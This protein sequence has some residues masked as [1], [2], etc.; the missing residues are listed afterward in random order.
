MAIVTNILWTSKD[1]AQA[2]HGELSGN[3]SATNLS[4]D[5]RTIEGGELFIAVRSENTDGHNYVADA[6]AKG[7]AAAVV[8]HRPDNVDANAP[9]IIV[10]DTQAA[11]EALGQTV[12]H[13][14]AARII[15]VTGSVGKTGTKNMLAKAFGA[16]GQVHASKAS[17]NNHLGVP[18]SL[19][20]MHE[21]TDFGI[22]EIGMNHSG[23][24][25]P[26]TKQVRPHIAIIT[27]VEAAHIGNFD[28]ERDIAN[29]KAEIFEGMKK[30][31]PVILNKDNKW[32]DHLKAIA[33][34]KGLKVH[35]FG[36]NKDADAHIVD[37]VIAANGSRIKAQI[38]DETVSFNLSVPGKHIACNAL[39]VLLAVKLSG[40]NLGKAAR[41]L[42]TMQIEAGRGLH[43]KLNIGDPDN[44]VTLIDESYNANPASMQAAFKVLAM[45]DPGRG[46]R[47]IAV[48]GDMYELGKNAAQRHA[49]LALPLETAD[50][51]LV[52]TCGPL[53][54]NLYDKIP[55][56]RRGAHSDDN[57]KMAEIVPEVLVP[58]DVVMVKGSRGGGTKPRM[59]VVVEALRALPNKN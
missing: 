50:I 25:T 12:R 2:T 38:I 13:D 22:F 37:C 16:L 5:S 20:S 1:A 10:N 51:Q 41:A 9:L 14:T 17:Y 49:D 8:D 36:E 24:I 56:D 59:Q 33:E 39:S 3:W 35:S 15:A 54:K 18:L 31:A 43:E 58:G 57:E 29:A 19:A 44:P 55:Q 46:G 30:G 11:L 6:L 45:I 42:Q 4:I 32:F 7:A 47:R 34:S 27:N 53:M 23:E 48:L 52:Y 21:G 40:G 28:S 26:L